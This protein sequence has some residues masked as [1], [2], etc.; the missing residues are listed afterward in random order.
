MK[1]FAR[2]YKK[3]ESPSTYVQI[4]E[5]QYEDRWAFVSG[6]QEDLFKELVEKTSKGP[7]WK[8][9]AIA[10]LEKRYDLWEYASYWGER[11]LEKNCDFPEDDL[12]SLE[13]DVAYAWRAIKPTKGEQRTLI[14]VVEQITLLSNG[15]KSCRV[16]EREFLYLNKMENNSVVFLG[17]R[18]AEAITK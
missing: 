5:D 6:L 4:W 11:G 10:D 8:K 18:L 14:Y 16:P 17:E 15:A 7:A 13:S 9:L 1:G 12:D 3:V 2:N